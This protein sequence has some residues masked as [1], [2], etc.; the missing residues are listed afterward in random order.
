M[1]P[2][3]GFTETPQGIFIRQAIAAIA[4]SPMVGTTVYHW[5]A[6]EAK[7][8]TYNEAGQPD[9]LAPT[10][11]LFDSGIDYRPNPNNPLK[12]IFCRPKQ[13]P[14]QDKGGIY[15]QGEASL[16]LVQDPGEVFVVVNDRPKRQDRFQIA[17]GIYYATA[18]VMPC[19]MGDTV[20]AFQVFLSRER[21]GVKEDGLS[22]Y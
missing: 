16:Y 5:K 2:S 6:V 1:Q 17:G 20:A 9:Y 18:P 19:Q 3:L 4:S 22:R 21:F 12:G 15:Y 11:G 13:T 8:A 10:S 7:Q 14:F